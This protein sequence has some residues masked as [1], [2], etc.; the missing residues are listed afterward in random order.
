MKKDLT[1]CNWDNTDDFNSEQYY[2][3]TFGIK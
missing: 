3:E 2:N 1:K